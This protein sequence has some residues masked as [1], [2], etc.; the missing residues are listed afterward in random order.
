LAYQC[1]TVSIGF[2]ALLL[3]SALEIAGAVICLVVC[4]LVEV[5]LVES[6]GKSFS[7]VAHRVCPIYSGCGVRVGTVTVVTV[8]RIT[9]VAKLSCRSSIVKVRFGNAGKVLHHATT[10]LCVWSGG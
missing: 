10:E 1:L 4:G 8:A 7:S 2:G 5:E 6:P 9:D 3:G